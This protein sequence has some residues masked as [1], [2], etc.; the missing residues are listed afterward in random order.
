MNV[1][2]S[3]M[4]TA[5]VTGPRTGMPAELVAGLGASVAGQVALLAVLAEVTGVVGP[6]GWLVGIGYAVIVA[7]MLYRA[8]VRSGAVALGAAN[9]VTLLRAVL[10]GGVAALVADGIVRGAGP[11]AAA[12]TPAVTL[13]VLALVLDTVDGRVARWTGSVSALGARFDMEVD[14]FL[15]LVLS[16]AIAPAYGAWVL[17]IGAARYLLLIAGWVLPWL[18]RPVPTRLWGK[19]VAAVQGIVLTV[20]LAGALPDPVI[21]LALVTSLALLVQSFAGQVRWLWHHRTPSPAP[22]S[23]PARPL[24]AAHR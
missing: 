11:V 17:L 9:R 13:A 6:V 5:A 3:P 16:A 14:A 23:P 20:A 10:V 7:V 15:I 24:V 22:S 8:L 21:D 1:S 4:R 2:S 18:R 19:V 12:V